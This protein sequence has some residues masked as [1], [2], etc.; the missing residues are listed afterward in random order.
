MTQP[1]WTPRF[2]FYLTTLDGDPAAIALDLGAADHAPVRTHPRRLLVR[3]AMKQP[4]PDGLQSS[5]ES[6]SLATVEDRLAETIAY[7]LEGWMVGRVVYRGNMD[8]FFY[9]PPAT[10]ED[11]TPLA[12]SIERSCGDYEVATNWAGDASWEFYFDFLFPD[13][14]TMQTMSN[15]A[16]LAQL[17]E[18]GDDPA[19]V[20]AIDHYA[21]FESRRI[22]TKIA[23]ALR[24]RGF[25]VDAPAEREDGSFSLHFV[26]EDSLAQGRIDEVTTEILGLLGEDDGAYDGWGCPVRAPN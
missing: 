25:V 23:E 1:P 22:A 14:A 13:R 12:E 24:G 10:D 3:L 20:R 9:A 6:K 18:A 21:Y 26:R 7:R 11:A 8:I 4:R 2:D 15:R 16:V 19:I 5:D 17:E